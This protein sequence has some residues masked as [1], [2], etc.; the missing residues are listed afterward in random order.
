M[1]EPA[2]AWICSFCGSTER[3][4]ATEIEEAVPGT[5]ATCARCG[6]E[7]AANRQDRTARVPSNT[8]DA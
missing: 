1:S 8:P 2:S 6:R 3:V 5:L 4:Q 7:S